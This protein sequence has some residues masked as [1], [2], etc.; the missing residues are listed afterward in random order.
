MLNSTASVYFT[1]LVRWHLKQ[2]DL[3]CKTCY[4]Y[5]PHQQHV[6]KTVLWV[7]QNYTNQM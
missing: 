6:Y 3:L 5:H 2:L 1:N 7:A 4:V